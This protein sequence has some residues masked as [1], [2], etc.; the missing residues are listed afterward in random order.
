MPQVLDRE[1]E[2]IETCKGCPYFQA[3]NEPGRR[4][5]RGWCAQ[6]NRQAYSHHA[7]TDNCLHDLKKQEA[8]QAEFE[9]HIEEQAEA[10]APEVVA[11]KAAERNSHS[12]AVKNKPVRKLQSITLISSSDWQTSKGRTAYKQELW[13]VVNDQGKVYCLQGIRNGYGGLSL[14]CP[15][16]A[17]KYGRTCYHTKAVKAADQEWVH[18][19]NRGMS[20][21]A[22]AQADGT[23]KIDDG[24]Y[25][26]MGSI[27]N[28]AGGRGRF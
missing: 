24:F 9:A 13:E 6:Y 28:N 23:V 4:S 14:T 18:A 12:V 15:C 3:F 20:R 16:E 7:I 8:A 2:K 19:E 5:E 21:G 10:I 22:I 26:A 11:P 27:R 25:Q 17:G 1:V